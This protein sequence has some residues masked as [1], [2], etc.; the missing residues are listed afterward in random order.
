MIDSIRPLTQDERQ[1]AYEAAQDA[2]IRSIG[3]RPERHQFT[4]HA[5]SQFPPAVTR[6]ITVLCLVL[7][8]AAFVPS[9]IRL[10]V[11]GSET[12]G[13]TINNTDAKN[14]VGVAT[15]LSAEIGQVVF[16]LA[17]ATLGTTRSARRLLYISAGIATIIALTGNVQ[18][19][20]P[21]HVHSPFAWL[22]AI[23]PPI[24]V[25]STSYVLKGQMLE[26]IQQRHAN[27]Q[28]Y[29]QALN[30][31]QY[32][33]R[34]PESHPRWSQIYANAI[35]DLLRKKNARRKETLE[36]MTSADWRA[37]V[38]R[39]LQADA[40]YEEPIQVSAHPGGAPVPF[41]AVSSNGNGNGY[42]PVN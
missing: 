1:D 2:V 14:L 6:L 30:D 8:A 20:L 18:K 35:R 29:K 37:A 22:E 10:Y 33:T 26:S 7:L 19:A 21:G 36:N 9:A 11:M 40:W 12:F 17:L 28:A 42:H 3:S 24:L 34:D 38:W 15:V 41:S 27:E 5:E 4:Q 16:S 25:L 31:W 13:Q 23:A 39:E 32:S